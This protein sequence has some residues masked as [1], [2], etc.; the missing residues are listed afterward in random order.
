[1]SEKLKPGNSAVCGLSTDSRVFNSHGVA[2]SLWTKFPWPLPSCKTD[3][4]TEFLFTLGDF[5]LPSNLYPSI[6]EKNANLVFQN[7]EEKPF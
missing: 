5:A 3:Q 7:Q 6:I 2:A 4:R 1:M